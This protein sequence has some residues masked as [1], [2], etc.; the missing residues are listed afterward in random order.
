MR[1]Q[2]MGL[3]RGVMRSAKLDRASFV[4]AN[5]ARVVLEFASLRGA[6]LRGATLIG[7]ELA[8]A[9]LEGADVTEAD[10]ANADVTSAR[11]LG[12]K[13]RASA[14]NL[15]DLKSLDRAIVD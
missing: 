4:N 6:S 11:L 14:R 2:S 13:G 5:L 10:F 15:Q 8:G 9:D 12:L 3:M 1:N 7:A